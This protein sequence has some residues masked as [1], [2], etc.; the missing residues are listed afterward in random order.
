[1]IHVWMLVGMMTGGII[2]TPFSSEDGC[3]AAM[4]ALPPSIV[5]DAEC[6]QIEMLA[7]SSIY[8]PEIAPLPRPKGVAP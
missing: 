2:T 7:P 5:E 4:Q 6:I 8:A 1:M 3:R